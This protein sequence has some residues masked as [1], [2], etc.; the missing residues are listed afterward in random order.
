M[1]TFTIFNFSGASQRWWAFKQMVYAHAQLKKCGNEFYKLLGSGGGEGFSLLPDFG[2][3]ILLQTWPDEAVATR[4]FKSNPLFL[5]YLDMCSECRV[6]HARAYK[7]DG[8]WNGIN[9]FLNQEGNA[10][11]DMLGVLTRASIKP[12]LLWQF[13]RYV[14][15]VS[16]K[17]FQSPGLIFA[18]G[19]GELPLV[20]QATFSLWEQ[21]K[22]MQH[23]A[24]KQKEHAA[25]VKKT[26]ELNWYS[27]ELFAR[28]EVLDAEEYKWAL[29]YSSQLQL[30]L[31]SLSKFYFSRSKSES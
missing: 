4:F 23:F 16:K 29:P 15:G 9:P 5:E 6:I 24:Y 31:N 11:P 8:T 2:T 20:E 7:A 30:N 26:R 27:E 18:K 25:V 12:A 1:T 14:P 10:E 21:Q 28:F 13:W 17:I 22:A 19:I 3:Y